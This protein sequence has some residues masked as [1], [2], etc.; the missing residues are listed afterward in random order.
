MFNDCASHSVCVLPIH[1]HP[2]TDVSP[3]SFV[4]QRLCGADFRFLEDTKLCYDAAASHRPR[5]RGLLWPKRMKIL[6]SEARKRNVALQFLSLGIAV[7]K[8]SESRRDHSLQ[9]WSIVELE[10]EIG[11][12]RVLHFVVGTEDA[13]LVTVCHLTTQAVSCLAVCH[14]FLLLLHLIFRRVLIICTCSMS[15]L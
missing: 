8:M 9:C 4:I 1:R 6:M 5:C 15:R 14:L 12:R 2:S 13:M 11:G 3:T 10:K 7:W